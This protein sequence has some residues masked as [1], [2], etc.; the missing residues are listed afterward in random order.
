MEATNK[1]VMALKRFARNPGLINGV[2]RGVQF[3]QLSKEEA[4]ELIKKCLGRNG[5]AS[6]GSEAISGEFR[7]TACSLFGYIKYY[8][9]SIS[10]KSSTEAISANIF[11]YIF[12][13]F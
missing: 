11:V 2:F 8:S 4:S 3:D 1:Q 13:L 5:D 10:V 9:L 6:E 7:I 12:S